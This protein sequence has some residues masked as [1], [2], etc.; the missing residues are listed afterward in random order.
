MNIILKKSLKKLNTF[1]VDYYIHLFIYS[2]LESYIFLSFSNESFGR[3]LFYMISTYVFF[4]LLAQLSKKLLNVFIGFSFLLSVFMY[5]ISQL[6]GEGDVELSCLTAIYYTNFDESFSYIKVVPMRIYLYILLLLGYS[7]Y[8]MK[9]RYKKINNKK[10]IWMG[11][12]LLVILHCIPKKRYSGRYDTYLAVL[13]IRRT[14]YIIT[15]MLH[16]DKEHHKMLREAKRKSSWIV[17]GSLPKD[18]DIVIVVGESVRKDMLHSYG[19]PIKNTKFI[20]R[21]P[22]IEFEN[23]ISCGAHTVPSLM[24]TLI[25]SKDMDNNAI[26]NNVITL[27]RAMGYR[28]Y[29]I[30]STLSQGNYDSAIS[31][32]GK[33]ADENV[34][35]S[36]KLQVKYDDTDML[37]HLDKALNEKSDRP[38]LIILHMVG[39][40]PALKDRVDAEYDEFIGNKDISYYNKSIKKLDNFL[41]KVYQDLRNH[42]RNFNLIYFSD[43]GLYLNEDSKFVHSDD[44]KNSY[45]VPLIIFGSDIDRME[46]IKARRVGKDFLYLLSELSGV[47]VKNFSQKYKFVS[48][49]DNGEKK[50]VVISR[51]KKVEYDN[52]KYRSMN[53]ILEEIKNNK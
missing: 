38:K 45:D 52:L 47:K 46:S 1:G 19:F 44:Y 39:S 30:S 6:T 31:I 32:I 21:T 34:F 14:V 16:I 3:D 36:D 24:R 11:V 41:E 26:S 13:P 4:V 27:G 53:N 28:T 5:S 18:K 15:S 20:D 2:L 25:E 22:N 51:D 12:I 35:V 42:K 10:I 49:E 48:E 50:T 23:Y 7:I 33:S 37:P 29:W 43:H 8:L 9:Y 40:H 17:D